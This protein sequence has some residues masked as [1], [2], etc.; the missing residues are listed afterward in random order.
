MLKVKVWNA[1]ARYGEFTT[2]VGKHVINMV[3]GLAA[4]PG[5]DI[6]FVVPYDDWARDQETG[7][8]GPL[9][10]VR[11]RRFRLT[12]RSAELLWLA[13]ANPTLDEPGTDWIYAPRERFAPSRKARSIVTVHDVYAFEPEH[14]FARTRTPA[15]A[16][17]RISKAIDQADI[18]AVVSKFTGER[19]QALFNAASNKI[20]VVGNGVEEHF[21]H[22]PTVAVEDF[23]PQL[24]TSY[25]LAVGGLTHKKGARYLLQL[26]ESL[27]SCAAQITLAITGPVEEVYRSSLSALRNVRLLGRGYSNHQMH[28]LIASAD[29]MVVLSEYEGFGIPVLEAMASG[30]PVVAARR[31]ALPEVA[32]D[33]GVIVEPTD[34][35][36]VR[37]AVMDIIGDT[38]WR[39]DL[40]SR[41]LRQAAAHQWSV[42]V[43]RLYAAMIS[44]CPQRPLGA[45][46]AGLT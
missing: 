32:G 42:C 30:V 31:A 44:R 10:M 17:E 36:A 27:Q 38:S 11:A 4:K 22:R 1:S 39:R 25:V 14:R 33:A 2:G 5:I 23:V 28:A 21:F 45:E 34:T 13:C 43:E 19:V 37:D 7:A 12:R 29:A 15:F 6:E 9:D 18:V 35:T 40:I 20:V 8:S 41:G 16:Y 26:A 3:S 46:P 24:G